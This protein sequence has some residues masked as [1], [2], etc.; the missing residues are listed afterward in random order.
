MKVAILGCGPTGLFVAH[1]MVQLGHDITIYSRKRRS[2]MFGAQ[3]LHKPIPGLTQSKPITVKYQLQGSA[4]GYRNK[5][6]SGQRVDSVS[7]ESLAGEHNAWDIREAYYKAWELYSREIVDTSGVDE[8]NP[9]WIRNELAWNN[10]HVIISTIPLYHLC[11]DRSSHKFESA[12]ILAIGDAPERGVWVPDW[13]E[14]PESSVLCNGEP[15]TP[16]YRQSRIY[17]YGTVE[18]PSSAKGMY[19][20]VPG[21]PP[22]EVAIVRKPIS[23]TCDCYAN[24][25][26]RVG[27]YGCWQKGYLSHQAYYETLEALS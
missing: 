18:W 15:D 17:G 8:I 21:A 14:C 25:I 16:W 19:T 23:T 11:R 22:V 6:Y 13:F 12:S 9:R 5:V 4:D 26:V 2:E 20:S 10:H 3:Y 27:R 24:S 1:A 7:P